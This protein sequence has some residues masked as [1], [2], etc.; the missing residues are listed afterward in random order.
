MNQLH[1]YKKIKKK[2]LCWILYDVHSKYTHKDK[3][4]YIFDC[5]DFHSISQFEDIVN[6]MNKQILNYK[7]IK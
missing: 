3:W 2:N 6:K 5:L 7:V 1:I 4:K